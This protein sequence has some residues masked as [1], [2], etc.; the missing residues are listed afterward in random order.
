MT[1]F[2]YYCFKCDQKKNL[3]TPMPKIKVCKQV[4][5]DFRNFMNGTDLND[6]WN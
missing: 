3:A 2:Y 1:V 5:K 6:D 4:G